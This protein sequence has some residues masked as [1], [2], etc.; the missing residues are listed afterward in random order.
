MSAAEAANL[1][2]MQH[3]LLTGYTLTDCIFIISGAL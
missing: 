3:H 2:S 1:L